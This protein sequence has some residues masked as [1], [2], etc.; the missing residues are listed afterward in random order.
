M[1]FLSASD[2]LRFLSKLFSKLNYFPS[3][4]ILSLA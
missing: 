4:K 1:F 2:F 3:D